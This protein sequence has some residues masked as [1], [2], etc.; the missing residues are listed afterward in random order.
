MFHPTLL[1]VRRLIGVNPPFATLKI[2]TGDLYIPRTH[3]SEEQRPV[4][5]RSLNRHP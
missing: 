4:I 2:V 3:V 1:N 5:R